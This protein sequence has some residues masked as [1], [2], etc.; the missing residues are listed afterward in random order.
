MW[1]HFAAWA[2]GFIDKRPRAVIDSRGRSDALPRH[3]S[4]GVPTISCT[5][6]T[7]PSNPRHFQ[8]W[9]GLRVGGG[10]VIGQ[11]QNMFE[12][13]K[14]RVFLYLCKFRK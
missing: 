3:R 1:Q 7:L 6:P 5:P 14:V 4:A 8:L 11:S 10:Q 2:R 9:G 12:C 13:L